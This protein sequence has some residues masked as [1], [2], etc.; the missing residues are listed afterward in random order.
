[1]HERVSHEECRLLKIKKNP[2]VQQHKRGAQCCFLIP[3]VVLVLRKLNKLKCILG[4]IVYITDQRK[5]KE[6]TTSGHYLR[7]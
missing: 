4:S 5:I 6:M 2:K 3:D 7:K 1:M